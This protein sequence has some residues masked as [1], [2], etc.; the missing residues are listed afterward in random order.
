[1]NT[2]HG[3]QPNLRVLPEPPVQQPMQPQM[4][5]PQGMPPMGVQQSMPP[6]PQGQQQ[7]QG[8]MGQQPQMPYQ[9]GPMGMPPR[10]PNGPPMGIPP[11]PG[12]G[13]N[14]GMV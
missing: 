6:P 7:P 1:M 8:Q 4:G 10:T 3:P 14:N 11:L 9:I 13:G 5:M 2:R 12:M